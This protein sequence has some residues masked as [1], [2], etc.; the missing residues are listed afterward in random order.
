LRTPTVELISMPWTTVGEPSLGLSVLRAVLDEEGIPS[1]V[2]HLNLFLLRFLRGATYS[3]IATTFAL[4]DFVFSGVIEPGVTPRQM[5]ALR[6][7]V[8]EMLQSGLIDINRFGGSEGVIQQILHLRQETIPDWLAEEADQ[9]AARGTTLVGLTSMFDQ[10]IAAVSLAK[11]VKERSPETLVAL[12]GYALRPPTGQTVITSF[13]WIDA[14]CIGEGENVITPLAWASVNKRDLAKVPGILVRS[15]GT[16]TAAHPAPP[17]VMDQS[18]VPNF[19]DYFADL[20]SLRDDHKVDIKV[21]TLPYETARGCWWG[22][23]KHCV[24]CG[25]ADEDLIYRHRSAETVLKALETLSNRYDVTSFRFSDY[26]LPHQYH[27][28][29]LPRLAQREPKFRLSCEMKAN[30]SLGRIRGMAA[31]GFVGVQPG[32]ESFSNSVLQRMDKGVTGILNVQTLV[33]GMRA[34]ITI[35]YNILYGL[36][37]DEPADYEAMLSL[38]PKLFHLDPPHS[39]TRIQIT[40][41]APLQADPERFKIPKARHEPAYEMIFSNEFR[42]QSGFSLDDYCYYFQ[43]PFRNSHRVEKCYH[44]LVD[45]VNDWKQLKRDRSVELSVTENGAGVA[46]FDT[47]ASEEGS[48]YQFGRLTA[49]VYR[50]CRDEIT[51]VDTIAQRTGLTSESVQEQVRLLDG[52]GLI[53][54]E[55]KSI[56]GLAIPEQED[57]TTAIDSLELFA[58]RAIPLLPIGTRP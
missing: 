4:N 57:L 2:R 37:D 54:R 10:T 52:H 29:L 53:Y 18:P 45:V 5:R 1:R 35:H 32:V 3:S 58:S 14:V 21:D 40:R 9:I 7:R 22:Q 55:G 26:I 24:F 38:I 36:P 20:A 19:D 51:T 17:V 30:S 39:H 27:K 41:Y 25:I 56:I 49:Q 11:L 47:R 16:C 13:P 23:V 50:Q 44:R 6:N 46:F 12:G 33:F 28:T 48:T 42:Q 15:N 31:A 43:H 34:G 8:A